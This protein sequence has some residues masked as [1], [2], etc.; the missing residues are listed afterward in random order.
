MFIYDQ[1]FSY[2]SNVITPKFEFSFIFFLQIHVDFALSA[3]KD[4]LQHFRYTRQTVL[5]IS[6]WTFSP[7]HN[8]KH[9][10]A[11]QQV[12]SIMVNRDSIYRIL[13]RSFRN[14]V[15]LVNCWQLRSE[16]SPTNI[17]WNVEKTGSGK[18]AK[19]IEE[20]ALFC[21]NRRFIYYSK[22]FIQDLVRDYCL[23]YR[24]AF[25][26]FWTDGRELLRTFSLFWKWAQIPRKTQKLL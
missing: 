12:G 6:G 2:P 14:L 15:Q 24:W 25:G 26:S 22:G 17:L 16:L 21:S 7:P 1:T 3:W 20:L 10:E 23:Y 18:Y 5:P 11:T 8:L 9:R 4:E 19:R 13:D